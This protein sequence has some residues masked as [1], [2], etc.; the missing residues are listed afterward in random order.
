MS[1]SG[2][3][4]LWT[5]FFFFF[6]IQFVYIV[7]RERDKAD[8]NSLGW[9]MV[10]AGGTRTCVHPHVSPPLYHCAMEAD[11]YWVDILCETVFGCG[12]E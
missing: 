9:S 12:D 11:L 2:G 10:G 4:S 8:I 1:V 7:Y 6:T 5:F 3:G